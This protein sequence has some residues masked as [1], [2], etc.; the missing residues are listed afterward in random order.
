[1]NSRFAERLTKELAR[2]LVRVPMCSESK[3]SILLSGDPRD[4]LVPLDP[5]DPLYPLNPLLDRPYLAGL[6]VSPGLTR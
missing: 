3:T 5:F 1:M 4:A 2:L 6:Y